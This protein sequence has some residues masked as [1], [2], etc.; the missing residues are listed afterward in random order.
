MGSCAVYPVGRF[1]PWGIRD[2]RR[3]TISSDLSD[4]VVG[5]REYPRTSDR[6][7]IICIMGEEPSLVHRER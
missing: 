5:W 6:C 2:G 4:M 1:A 7:Q 3:G